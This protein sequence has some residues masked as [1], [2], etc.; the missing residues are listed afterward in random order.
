MILAHV[1]AEALAVEI[2]GLITLIL[3]LGACLKGII[4]ITKTIDGQLDAMNEN[5]GAV[6]HLTEQM[7]PLVEIVAK[8]D[9][10]FDR[11]EGRVGGV[12]TRVDQIERLRRMTAVEERVDE[13]EHPA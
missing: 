13:L 3:F 2:G 6:T 1:T 4:K 11:V 7:G 10:R 8:H 5:T 12:E 9:E